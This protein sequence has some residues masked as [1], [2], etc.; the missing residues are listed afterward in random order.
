MNEIMFSYNACRNLAGRINHTFRYNS[1]L[2]QAIDQFQDPKG[3]TVMGEARLDLT[4]AGLRL[5]ATATDPNKRRRGHASRLARELEKSGLA[6]NS[7][8]SDKSQQERLQT[9][10]D[11]KA[12]GVKILV[13][14]DIAARGLDIEELPFV[15]NYDIP[16]AAEDYIHRIGRTGRAGSEGTAI[17]LM[18]PD[19]ERLVGDIEKLLKHSIEKLEFRVQPPPER[20]PVRVRSALSHASRDNVSNSALLSAAERA[21]TSAVQSER[22][23]TSRPTPRK[24]IAALLGGLKKI[25]QGT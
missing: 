14:T 15:I 18:A 25:S 8:H 2:E 5:L 19:E 1:V 17:S 22:L 13:A 10:G 20:D 11:F 9:L 21:R 12:G 16:F 24:E 6:A 4:R 7:I 3:L 23:V